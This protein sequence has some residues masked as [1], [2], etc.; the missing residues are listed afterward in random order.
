LQARVIIFEGEV[1]NVAL[2]GR[3]IPQF[4]AD[5]HVHAEVEGQPGLSDFAAA[6]RIK[7][8]WGSIFST[9]NCNGS[10]SCA[11]SVLPSMMSKAFGAVW[12]VLGRRLTALGLGIYVEAFSFYA[13]LIIRNVR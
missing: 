2:L 3:K 12:L 13:I 7:R 10:Y 9:A 4:A 11:M 1:Q 6:A 5:R 8:P